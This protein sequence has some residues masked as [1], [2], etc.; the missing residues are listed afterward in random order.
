MLTYDEIL[1]GVRTQ[2]ERDA[3]L[4]ITWVQCPNEDTWIAPIGD[5]YLLLVG[6]VW[7][8]YTAYVFNAARGELAVEHGIRDVET[9]KKRAVSL[10]WKYNKS[11]SDLL[12]EGVSS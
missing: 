6:P 2:R 8:T 9:A 12:E 11:I 4:T 5:V 3:P 1:A 10:A 7:R